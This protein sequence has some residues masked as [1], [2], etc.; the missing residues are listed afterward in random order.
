MIFLVVLNLKSNILEYIVINITM[1]IQCNYISVVVVYKDRAFSSHQVLP[2]LLDEL[3]DYNVVGLFGRMEA[4]PKN[5][6]DCIWTCIVIRNE[7]G[8][9]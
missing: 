7:Y 3:V 5:I 2:V 8:S 4:V 9:T 1:L 6:I